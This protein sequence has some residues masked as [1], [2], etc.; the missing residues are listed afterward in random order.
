M[1]YSFHFL[2]SCSINEGIFSVMLVLL[3]S[4]Y[5]I[6]YGQAVGVIT[7]GYQETVAI[8]LEGLDRFTVQYGCWFLAVDFRV[9]ACSPLKKYLVAFPCSS[10]A[11]GFKF[12]GN[13][14]HLRME[15][16]EGHG[17]SDSHLCLVR[18]ER[19]SVACIWG[20][21]C[22]KGEKNCCSNHISNPLPQALKS[23]TNSHSHECVSPIYI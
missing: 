15:H 3:C 14:Y 10:F 23:I 11:Q 13:A 4:L 7:Q 8:K 5:P 20:R 2:E 12:Q 1:K 21:L 17:W 22:I 6:L 16:K 18:K 19:I 9:H